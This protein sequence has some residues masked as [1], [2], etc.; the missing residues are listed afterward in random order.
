MPPSLTDCPMDCLK[1]YNFDVLNGQS[2]YT[3]TA[4]LGKNV[5]S[6][7]IGTQLQENTTSDPPQ[8]SWDAS[9]GI[10]HLF[11][12]PV[13]NANGKIYYNG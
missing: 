13:Q 2:D 11:Y 5:D 8:Y 4:L 1:P 6:L 10:L 9:T 12:A 3:L 7:F